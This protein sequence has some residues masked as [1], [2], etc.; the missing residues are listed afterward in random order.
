MTVDALMKRP[1]AEDYNYESDVL[2]LLRLKANYK[3]A[4]IEGLIRMPG[5][6]FGVVNFNLR[7]IEPDWCRQRLNLFDMKI[8]RCL[9]GRNWSKKPHSERPQWIA[10]PER[11]TFLHYNSLWDV[12][13]EHQERF[14]VEAPGIWREVMPSGD[15]HLQVIGEGVGEDVASRIYCG[16]TFHPRWTIDNTIL[17][18]DL[19]GGK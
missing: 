16:K 5:I 15:F 9:L 3:H 2:P 17:S 11:A 10:V 1:M 18:A 4:F 6:F 19:R 7:S 8:A 13:I 14:F 12:P